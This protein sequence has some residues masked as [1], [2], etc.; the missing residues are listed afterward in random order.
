MPLRVRGSV[1]PVNASSF[2][3]DGGSRT[4]LFPLNR[5]LAGARFRLAGQRSLFSKRQC[6]LERRPLSRQGSLAK[7]NG[8]GLFD[9]VCT[10]GV[11]L[12]S[13]Q[14]ALTFHQDF[15]EDGIDVFAIVVT[16]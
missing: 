11:A 4:D 10:C 2:R 3:E 14:T 8:G 13:L 1:W 16:P 7:R 15:A 9:D 5:A 12:V 6:V